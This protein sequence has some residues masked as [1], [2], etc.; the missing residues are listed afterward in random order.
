MGLAPYGSPIYVDKLATIVKESDDFPYYEL[1]ESYISFTSR[2]IYT[3]KLV[4]LLEHVPRES[5]EKIEQFHL[6]LA[7]SS[8]VLEKD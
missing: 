7:A 1:D 3:K 6:D 2:R 8:I 4:D 5:E